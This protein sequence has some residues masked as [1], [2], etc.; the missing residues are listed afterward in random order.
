MVARPA[1]DRC[2][3]CPLTPG[4]RASGRRRGGARSAYHAVAAVTRITPQSVARN[5]NA[6]SGQDMRE[7]DNDN[8]SNAADTAL[9]AWFEGEG[10]LRYSVL[11][12]E[13]GEVIE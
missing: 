5:A 9:T 1:P 3:P 12:D 7:T 8:F 10:L 13:A 11:G 4:G 2:A 6:T